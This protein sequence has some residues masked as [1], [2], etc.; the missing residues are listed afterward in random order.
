MLYE[1]KKTEALFRLLKVKVER[2]VEFQKQAFQLLG[3]LD[4]LLTASITQTVK[5]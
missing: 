5:H 3:C 4:T 2:E 1:S